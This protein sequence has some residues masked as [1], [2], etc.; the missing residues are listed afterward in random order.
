MCKH[1]L[2]V[3]VACIYQLA[4]ITLPSIVI[5]P[6]QDALPQVLYW[7]QSDRPLSSPQASKTMAY[8][9]QTSPFCPFNLIAKH[10]PDYI[11]MWDCCWLQYLPLSIFLLLTLLC[12][13]LVVIAPASSYKYMLPSPALN[14]WI[15]GNHGPILSLF[16]CKFSFFFLSNL[17]QNNTVCCWLMTI[18][19][20]H[21]FHILIT[22]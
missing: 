13:V 4:L 2:L 21:M 11:A 17:S 18:C 3:V 20:N 6:C 14:H 19:M 8:P 10:F 15:A 5:P 9:H 16:V 1:D 12:S 22:S 7:R